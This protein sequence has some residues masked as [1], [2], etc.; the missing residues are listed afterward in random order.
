MHVLNSI[1]RTIG[2]TAAY[3]DVEEA[4]ES[5]FDNPEHAPMKV[6]TIEDPNTGEVVPAAAAEEGGSGGDGASAG[7]V[8][9][10]KPV[11]NAGSNIGSKAG[12]VAGS[13]AGGE[14]AK[15]PGSRRNSDASSATK[16]SNGGSAVK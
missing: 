8:P 14:E 10:S 4:H 7:S 9:V 13:L 6:L 1:V 2:K 12:S 11:S 16:K 15:V 3:M 5:H